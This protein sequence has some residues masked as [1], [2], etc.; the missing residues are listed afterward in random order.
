MQSK[1]M[2]TTLT[3]AIQ[4][5]SIVQ[6]NQLKKLSISDAALTLNALSALPE[7][8]N[9]KKYVAERLRAQLT[10][11][12]LKQGRP[13]EVFATLAALWRYDSSHVTGDH[14]AAALQRLIAAELVVGGPYHFEQPVVVAAHIQIALFM[15]LVAKPLPNVEAFLARIYRSRFND[16]H[17][18]DIR[19]VYIYSQIGEA[20]GLSTYVERYHMEPTWQHPIG[21]ATTLM[22]LKDLLPARRKQQLMLTLCQ[23]Q[24][25]CG[26]VPDQLDITTTAIV[27]NMLA[28][29]Q[30]PKKTALDLLTHQQSVMTAAH[31]M[32]AS[33]AEPLRTSAL[34]A[35]KDI[36]AA[37]AHFEI[38]SLSLL[39]AR[40]LK[41]PDTLTPGQHKNL[42]LASLY[43]WI[44]YTIYDDFLDDEGCPAQLPVANVA[45]RA[46]LDCFRAALPNHDIFLRYIAHIFS[47]MDEANAWEVHHCR[48]AIVGARITITELPRYRGRLIL[49]SRSFAHALPPLA[50]L[51]KHLPGNIKRRHIKTAFTHY[52][53]ARQ[54][55]DDLRDW[56][57]DLQKG[58]ASYVVTT[59]LRDTHIKPGTYNVATL[60]AA[61]QTCCR[62]TTLPKTC[63]YILQHITTSRDGFRKSQ[64]LQEHN[65][66]YALL[67]RLER[68]ANETLDTHGKGIAFYKASSKILRVRHIEST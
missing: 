25:N 36:T 6:K 50:V 1:L 57:D 11:D 49:A 2:Q 5:L 52:L 46:S 7:L 10:I 12:W 35:L 64:C 30:P 17:N 33:L 32:F 42:G 65:D 26:V 9:I 18:D 27:V 29:H 15:R 59:I 55:S 13:D 51:E 39:F 48:F 40:A 20:A 45:M 67:D 47:T 24:N 41:V 53:I 16:L 44:A 56:K 14:L 23:Q 38:T 28:Q 31:T 54:L 58:Q 62:R 66:F 68:A 3:K 8:T 4:A 22:V 60:T 19:L 61:M 43:G 21:I 63:R 34:S 37:D